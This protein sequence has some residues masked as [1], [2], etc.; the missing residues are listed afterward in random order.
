MGDG[1]RAPWRKVTGGQD[2]LFSG[3]GGVLGPDT[4]RRTRW[5]ELEL[6]CGHMVEHTVR[7]TKYDREIHGRSRSLADV[8]PAP[9]KIRCWSC[10]L[11]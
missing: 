9:K 11:G 5:R 8:L 3:R 1:Y 2:R 6:E 4:P 7:Y 10:L